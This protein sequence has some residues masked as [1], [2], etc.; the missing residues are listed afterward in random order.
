MYVTDL[1][2]GRADHNLQ[3]G[4]LPDK[5]EKYLPVVT[6]SI[7]TYRPVYHEFSD[8][9]QIAHAVAK[10]MRLAL[11]MCA[12]GRLHLA[13]EEVDEGLELSPTNGDLLRLKRE[14]EEQLNRVDER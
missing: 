2:V 10:K 14:I 13:L 11:A 3:Y 4:A 6:K 1:I 5:Y 8:E 9:E 7:E 12:S